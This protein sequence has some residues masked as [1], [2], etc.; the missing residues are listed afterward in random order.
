MKKK[1]EEKRRVVIVSNRLPFTIVGQGSDLSFV[2]SV[3]GLAT[4][5]RSFLSPNTSSADNEIEYIW[6]GWPGKTI[7]PGR[8]DEIREQSFR[9]HRSVPVFLDEEEIEQF[10]QG[11][12]NKTIWPLFH[13]FQAYTTYEAGFWEEYRIVNRAFRDTLLGILR[14]DDVVWI[15]DYH[16]MLLPEL[17]R[18]EIP[19]LTIGFFLHIPFPTFETYRLLPAGWRKEILHGLL[20]ADLVGFHTY[21]YMQDFLRCVLRI[22]G[23]E[24]HMGELLLP[25][26]MCRAGTFP[27]GIDFERFETLAAG[28]D[29][30][31]GRDS[32]LEHLGDLR[33]ILSV[34]RL[35]Y[36]KG[37]L[38]RLEGFEL[39]LAD[40]PEWRGK[41]VLI[42]VV[43]PSRIGVEHYDTMK[44]QLEEQVGKINGEYGSIGWT[45]VQYQYR[46]LA[47]AELA[48][49]YS[50]A[51]VALI[52]PLRDGMNLV[53]KEYMASRLDETG[54]LILSEMAGAAKE[55]NEAIIINPNTRDEISAAIHEAL[56][57]PEEEQKRRNTIM[58]K[59]LRRYD[60]RRWANEFFKEVIATRA[61]RESMRARLLTASSTA[62]LS[63]EFSAAAHRLLLLDY[64][65]TL[66][67]YFTRPHQA[68]PTA[69]VL[70]L[71]TSLA[72]QSGTDL[73]IISGRDRLTLEEWF[74]G[75]PVHLVAEHG[76]W[77]RAHGKSWETLKTPTGD[78]KPK[79]LS[80]LETYADRLPGAL[81]EEK[82]FSIAWHYRGADHDQGVALAREVTD[83]LMGFTAN[84]DVQVLQGN[85]VVEV[86][87]AGINKGIAAR[88]WLSRGSPDF[89]I[90]MG[91]DWTDEDM[92]QAIPQPAY[93]IRVGLARSHARFSL[94]DHLHAVRLLWELAG[95]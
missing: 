92:F 76:I 89:I 18:R 26:R 21:D 13:Y 55:L 40:H 53:A 84:I 28:D 22:L 49:M 88:Y 54:V 20:G 45:P 85:K 44:K 59:R 32:M 78:W 57:M 51:H 83:A 65:G 56:L 41:V 72:S 66:V 95:Q 11:F 15:H 23:F 38:K 94:R 24:H 48:G 50:A 61:V 17:L 16:L 35:D 3:G 9:L 10:Y 7:E 80:I 14:P 64:D 71:L 39:F 81:I 68:V 58:R 43:V 67:P 31:K 25:E 4:G 73:V 62:R 2:E 29:A 93:S 86:R 69:D 5:L 87:N 12:C 75:I 82:E 27:M 90:A 70:A 1:V 74:N 77:V 8:Q 63:A 6:V 36:T 30:R 37:I 46:A 60:V 52:T 42:M 79:L 91:D 47:P 33:I 19:E 34:D